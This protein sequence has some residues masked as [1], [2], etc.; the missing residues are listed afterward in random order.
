MR[1][2][3][4]KTRADDQAT[5]LDD[6][7]YRRQMG[8]NLRNPT[9]PYQYIR[10]KTRRACAVHDGAMLDGILHGAFPSSRLTVQ[11]LALERGRG[12]NIERLDNARIDGRNDVHC[13]L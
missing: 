3:V 2:H 5:R 4:D 7:S 13:R 6:L 10:C 11:R 1:M 8:G 9:V 12:A